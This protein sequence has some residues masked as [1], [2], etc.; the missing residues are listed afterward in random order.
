MLRSEVRQRRRYQMRQRRERDRGVDD[1]D[2]AG[3]GDG[4]ADEAAKSLGVR[5]LRLRR[6]ELSSY[7]G[8]VTW[9][10]ESPWSPGCCDRQ[11]VKAL[12]TPWQRFR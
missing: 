4:N 5:Q 10:L 1:D 3:S 9:K 8:A 11:P 2:D 7:E 6:M 12:W